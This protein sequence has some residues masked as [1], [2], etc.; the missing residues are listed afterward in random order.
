M[1]EPALTYHFSYID[2]ESGERL[3]GKVRAGKWHRIWL[4]KD[5][6]SD[7]GVGD[8]IR[9]RRAREERHAWEF[10]YWHSLYKFT[11]FGLWILGGMA[12]QLAWKRARG[13][14]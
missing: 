10:G 8:T 9:L 12:L 14:I 5:F 2:P 3:R 1:T 4:G 11:I 13:Q 6:W 7:P